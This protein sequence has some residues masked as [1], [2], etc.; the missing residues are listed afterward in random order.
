VDVH[1]HRITN[2][3]GWHK[4]ETTT[5]EQTR[6][7]L[8]S[9]LPLELRKPI[10]PLLVGFGQVI[11]LP[12]GPRCDSCTLATEGLCPSARADVSA[13]GRKPIVYTHK[14]ESKAE[15]PDAP[16]LD[17]AGL[18]RVEDEVKKEVE[19]AKIECDIGEPR[20]QIKFEE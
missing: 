13:K 10:N 17:V 2:R 1:V 14:T 15:I 6:L 8:Q 4:P 11:C 3:L 20:V 7:N 16:D 9:W 19:E 5:P 18:I 12:I